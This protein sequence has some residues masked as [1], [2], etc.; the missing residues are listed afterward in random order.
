M[1]CSR[2]LPRLRLSPFLAFLML[3]SV[4]R[5]GISATTTRVA[6][7]LHRPVYATAPPGDSRL[8]ILEQQGV[9]KIL[10]NGQ[11]NST[12]FLDIHTL[13]PV[14]SGNDERGLLGMTF[15]PNFATNGYFY[16]DYDDLSSNTIIVRYSVSG[17]PD[18]ADPNSA[19]ILWTITQPYTNHKGG[20]L[21]FSPVDHY[22]YIGMGDGGSEGDPQHRGQDTTTVLGKMVRIDV[23]S[24]QGYSIPPTNP[25][26]GHPGMRQEIWAIGVRNPYRWSFDRAT[27]DM[28][29][30][31]VGQSS[32]EEIDY[33]PGNDHGGENYGWSI[34]EGKHCYNPSNGCDSTG[35]HD[36]IWEYSH[37]NGCAI[38][39]GYVYR[40]ASIPSYQGAYFFSDFCSSK[41]WSLRYDGHQVTEF[42]DHTTELAPGGG[43]TISAVSGF[44]E[45]GFG[46]LYIV[47]RGSGTDGQ[48]FK[49]VPDP[50]GLKGV[51]GH[52][53]ELVVSAAQPNPLTASSV[54]RLTTPAAGHLA[55]AILD[56]AG[57]QVRDL[58]REAS[59]PGS[60]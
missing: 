9:I 5:P 35:L 1:D 22:L 34:M 60:Q 43:L 14:V 52:E 41:I 46:E 16:L 17:N 20:T 48:V 25:F 38:V 13:I 24:G 50:T 8:F 23:S 59:G 37:A 40:G 12:P 36:P 53:S 3:A 39:G 7:G 15:D 45:D 21:L 29:V 32:W 44:G 6:S 2:L 56:A 4:S 57:R 31:E 58:S 49:I 30:G 28:W 54:F 55:L 19:D 42:L 10:E 11:I 18:V 47:C 51:S 26:Y 27:G 33:A